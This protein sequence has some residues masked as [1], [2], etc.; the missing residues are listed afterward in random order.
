MRKDG[1]RKHGLPSFLSQVREILVPF[2]FEKKRCISRAEDERLTGVVYDGI[3]SHALVAQLAVEFPHQGAIRAEHPI[4]IAVCGFL[5]FNFN[6]AFPTVT[7]PTEKK[8]PPV[9]DRGMLFLFP[10]YLVPVSATPF[11]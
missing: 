4:D 11:T 7:Q 5:Y 1:I 10:L 8:H 9:I 6:S 3:W 2:D